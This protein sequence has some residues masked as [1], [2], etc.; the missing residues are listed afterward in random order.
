MTDNKKNNVPEGKNVLIMEVPFTY[1]DKALCPLYLISVETLKLISFLKSL[2]N[3]ISFIDTRLNNKFMWRKKKAGISGKK[4]LQ[5]H[6]QTISQIELKEKIRNLKKTPDEILLLAYLPFAPYTFDSEVIDSLIE[7]CHSM[8]PGVDVK[9]GG[10][11]IRLFPNFTD[12]LKQEIIL[13]D[14]ISN[15]DS[16]KPDFSVKETWTYGV[17]QIAKGCSNKCS[18]CS[19][20]LDKPQKLSLDPVLDYMKLADKKYNPDVFWNWD[21]NVLL[22]PDHFEEF[23]DKYIASGIKASLR[24]ALGFQPDR[25]NENLIQKIIDADL[26]LIT[27]PFESGTIDSKNNIEK[28]Y[29]IISSIKVLNIFKKLHANLKRT[30]SSFIIGYPH[31][32]IKSIFRIFISIL[33]MGSIPLPFP[34][35]VF[36][37]TKEYDESIDLLKDKGLAGLHGQLWPLTKDEDVEDYRNLL[38]FLRI[39]DL[40]VAREKSSLLKKEWKAVFEEEL[41]LNSNFIKLCT[42][43]KEDSLEELNRIEKEVAIL[44]NEKKDEKILYIVANPKPVNDSVSQTLGEYFKKTY[45]EKNPTASFIDVNLYNEGIEFIDEGFINTIFKKDG[46]VS[47]KSKRLIEKADNYIDMIKDADKIVIVS[48]MW[49]MSIPAIMK[50]FLEMIASRL[51]FYHNDHFTNKKVLCIF[52]RDGVYSKEGS[53]FINVQ[54]KS[55]LA[56]FDFMGI[57][58]DITYICAEGTHDKSRREDI[59]NQSK[60]DILQVIDIFSE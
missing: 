60:K 35:Y 37:H 54:E 7:I 58:R 41:K 13:L 43:A 10:D 46:E 3:D 17:F 6:I 59:I 38:R 32:D 49:T 23:L 1:V 28:P 30:Q 57:G 11:F 55:I 12:E 25:L 15:I 39:R 33:N 4:E 53:R 22:F 16:F 24:F 18:F 45:L 14:K 51:F 9:L 42:E 44:S 8:L 21:P 36:P 40:S 20:S 27:I 19:A 34:L 2:D 31:D 5:M 48:P 47:E 56:A 52:S 50:A 29:S 26:S